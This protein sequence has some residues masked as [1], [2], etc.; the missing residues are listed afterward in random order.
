MKMIDVLIKLANDEIE[1]K[2]TLLVENEQGETFEY[3]YYER[4]CVFRGQY[5]ST[6]E[7][8]FG[9]D[10]DFLNFE[11]KLIPPKPKKYQLKLYKDDD[12]S[13]M[14]RSPYDNIFS[15]YVSDKNETCNFITK[16]TQKEIDNDKFL[17]FIEMHCVK[18]EVEE[19]END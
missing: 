7:D 18:E 9:I 14:T 16:F 6:L 15:Y 1:D 13:Y 2:S 5:C 11:V 10:K 12:L 19:N 8:D 17:K 3:V 4:Y